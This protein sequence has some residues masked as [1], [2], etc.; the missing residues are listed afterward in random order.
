MWRLWCRDLEKVQDK[1]D[2]DKESSDGKLVLLW[3]ME[4]DDTSCKRGADKRMD[5]NH[6]DSS[7]E[8]DLIII[9]DRESSEIHRCFFP[10]IT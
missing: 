8:G 1:Q 10:R 6:L 4:D 3:D 7:F 9:E 5:N 2:S